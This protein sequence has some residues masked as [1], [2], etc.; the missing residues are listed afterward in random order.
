MIN[1]ATPYICS[2]QARLFQLSGN[3]GQDSRDF[4]EKFMNSHVAW[5]MDDGYSRYQWMCEEYT[6]WDFE[7]EVG[8]VAKG[9]ACQD[10]FLWWMGYF[11]RYWQQFT[12][13]ESREIYRLAD[14]DSMV[15]IYPGY[16]T[17]PFEAAVPRLIEGL[18]ATS[19][20]SLVPAGKN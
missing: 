10:G 4:V 18:A 9:D 2:N 8:G 16:H 15:E 20:G 14:F 3:M 19:A 6:M 11:Y 5:Q 7:Q 13:K 1:D 12:G 17:L